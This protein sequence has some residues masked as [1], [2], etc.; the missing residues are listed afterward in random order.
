MADRATVLRAT[1]R[2]AASE[3][4]AHH[5]ASHKQSD[6]SMQR[7]ASAVAPA[8]AHAAGS[9]LGR[10]GEHSCAGDAA[11]SMTLERADAM[12]AQLAMAAYE[13]RA[14]A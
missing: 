14:G 13:Q 9:V 12:P 6:Y 2:V 3:A 5:R 8:C 4:W 1:L 7:V 11:I 10:A